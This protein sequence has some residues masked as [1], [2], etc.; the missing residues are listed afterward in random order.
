M[1]MEKG[2]I[3]VGA[4]GLQLLAKQAIDSLDKGLIELLTNAD[5]SYSRLEKRGQVV[6]R[7]SAVLSTVQ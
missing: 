2:K 5:E 3:Q 1:V 4:R 6:S 7:V